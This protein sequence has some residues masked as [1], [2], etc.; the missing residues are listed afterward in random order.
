MPEDLKDQNSGKKGLTALLEEVR[1][2]VK[3]LREKSGRGRQNAQ[4]SGKDPSSINPSFASSMMTNRESRPGSSPNVFL[5]LH[6]AK[7]NRDARGL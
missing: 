7:I 1:E 5:H 6:P 2:E 4:G 3:V